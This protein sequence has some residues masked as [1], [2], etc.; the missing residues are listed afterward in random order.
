MLS[1]VNFASFSI[2]CICLLKLLT[3]ALQCWHSVT[4]FG[5]SVALQPRQESLTLANFIMPP[6][7]REGVDTCMLLVWSPVNQGTVASRV[8]LL[9]M[10]KIELIG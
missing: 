2:D 10:R 7:A 5:S 1:G 4:S 3:L 9:C 8:K 6:D